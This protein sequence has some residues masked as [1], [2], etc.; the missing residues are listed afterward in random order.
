MALVDEDI[1]GIVSANLFIIRTYE[2]KYIPEILKYYFESE[3]GQRLIEGIIKGTAI[4]S[5][6]YKDIETLLV[7]DIPVEVQKSIGKDE[8]IKCRI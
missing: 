2:D 7:P 6:A 1:R 8:K 4:K 5:I 3:L